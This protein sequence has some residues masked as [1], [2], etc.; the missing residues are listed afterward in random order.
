MMLTDIPGITVS[1]V[2]HAVYRIFC[3]AIYSSLSYTFMLSDN[4]AGNRRHDE[5]KK[6]KGRKQK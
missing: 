4:G 5:N 1:A 6:Q 3:P 2:G